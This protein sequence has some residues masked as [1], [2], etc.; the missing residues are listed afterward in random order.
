MA[1]STQTKQ[2]PCVCILICDEENTWTYFN[3]TR[4][5]F[6]FRPDSII[7]IL[8]NYLDI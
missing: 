5:V 1:F 2:L 7:D 8:G 4:G 6:I 3:D